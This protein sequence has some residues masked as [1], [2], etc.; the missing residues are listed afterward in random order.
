MKTPKHITD[1]KITKTYCMKL[2]G[3]YGGLTDE[4]DSDIFFDKYTTD[5]G[6]PNWDV[7]FEAKFSRVKS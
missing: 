1:I 6:L 3:D 7:L 5:M 4:Y 2:K